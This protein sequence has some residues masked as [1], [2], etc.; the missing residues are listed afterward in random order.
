MKKEERE[1]LMKDIFER[2]RVTGEDTFRLADYET[3]WAGPEEIKRLKA[4][5][6]K[7]SLADELRGHGVRRF[8]FAER[9]FR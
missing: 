5:G 1:R 8:S 2:C 4:P 7:K 9:S 3:T 6:S